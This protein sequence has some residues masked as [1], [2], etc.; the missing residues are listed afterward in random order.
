MNSRSKGARGER[1]AAAAWAEA[2]GLP[3]GSCR[4]GQQFAGGTD[5]PDV[6][7]P[8]AN[9][10]LEVKRTERGNPYVW[11]EQAV[12]DAGGKVPVV[13]HKRNRAEWIAVIRLNDV[14]RFSQ[15]I[16]AASEALGRGSVSGDV[17]G[18]DL[19]SPEGAD[20]RHARLLHDG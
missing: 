20:E 8:L 15:E 14:A 11:L 12:R 2:L 19:P 10:H 16:A 3:V 6:V 4:R 5:S 13:L 1:T 9:I 18:A 7:Q 17:P